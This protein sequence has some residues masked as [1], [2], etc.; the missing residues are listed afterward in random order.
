[1]LSLT[2]VRRCEAQRVFLRRL[3]KNV[4]SET[5]VLSGLGLQFSSLSL[6]PLRIRLTRPWTNT[7]CVAFTVFFFLLGSQCF[8]QSDQSSKRHCKAF[9]MEAFDFSPCC[10][11]LCIL[12]TKTGNRRI[13]G[14]ISYNPEGLDAHAARLL[15]SLRVSASGGTAST[16]ASL[17]ESAPTAILLSAPPSRPFKMVS[18]APCQ[19]LL[20]KED[21]TARTTYTPSPPA[22]PWL[23]P[24]QISTTQAALPACERLKVCAACRSAPDRRRRAAPAPAAP[25]QLPCITSS[26]GLD[27]PCHA[28][29][30]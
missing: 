6:A 11:P 7:E 19:S 20:H 21:G 29:A 28:E 15:P 12:K 24:P 5:E 4:W 27:F 18:H 30:G 3:H 23:W 13:P 17:L 10:A 25:P 26:S 8:G 1:M 22:R 9:Y 14:V 2:V 16:A